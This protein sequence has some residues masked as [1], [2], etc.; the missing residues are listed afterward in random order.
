MTDTLLAI[1]QRYTGVH[2]NSA[3]LAQTRI[4]CLATVRATAP[5][6]LVHA[7]SRPLICLVLQGSKQVTLGPKTFSFAAG[8]S[9]LITADVP[10]VSQI[11]RASAATPYLSLVLELDLAVIADL[12]VEMKPGFVADSAPVRV[13]PSEAEVGRSRPPYG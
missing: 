12:A 11:T 9:L 13:H 4:P 8:E 7:I 5:S 2:A 10:T 6:G 3:G 1:V